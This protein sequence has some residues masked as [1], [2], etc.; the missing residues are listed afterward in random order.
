MKEKVIDTCLIVA[1]FLAALISYSGIEDSLRTK[2]VNYSFWIFCILILVLIVLTWV[3]YFV[4][5]PKS[6]NN[7]DKTKI[8]NYLERLYSKTDRRKM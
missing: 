1:T 7:K 5:K 6:Y 8:N 2:R 3:F 4:G